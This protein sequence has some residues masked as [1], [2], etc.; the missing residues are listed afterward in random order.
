MIIGRRDATAPPCPA[1]HSKR[2]YAQA[3]SVRSHSTTP[4]L[5]RRRSVLSGKTDSTRTPGTASPSWKLVGHPRIGLCSM[6][7]WAWKKSG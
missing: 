6:R 4:C 5:E 7:K 3:L 1:T 2:F